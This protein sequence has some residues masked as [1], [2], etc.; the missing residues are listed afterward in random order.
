MILYRLRCSDDH[1]FEGWFRNADAFDT[2]RDAGALECPVCGSKDVAKALMAPSIAKGREVAVPA[3]AAQAQGEVPTEIQAMHPAAKQAA[4]L[5]RQL[6]ALRRVVEE[7]C[8]YVGD[9]FAEE[10]RKIHYGEVDARGIYGE[11]TPE[12]S[13]RLRDEGIE[14]GAIPWVRDD[15]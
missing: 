11:S 14:F 12:E 4:E 9:R 7:N 13:E 15:A 5:K 8:D 1:E 2:Q 3:P 6:R 10:A